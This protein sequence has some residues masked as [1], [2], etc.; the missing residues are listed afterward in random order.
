MKFTDK[1]SLKEDFGADNVMVKGHR[2]VTLRLMFGVIPLFA[3]QLLRL[4]EWIA[5]DQ[6]MDSLGGYSFCKRLMR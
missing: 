5:K 6:F 2:K 4:I 1:I 3:D